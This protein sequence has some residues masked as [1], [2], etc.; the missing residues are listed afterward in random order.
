MHEP[1]FRWF[2][3]IDLK[4]LGPVFRSVLAANEWRW[5]LYSRKE[6]I[7]LFKRVGKGWDEVV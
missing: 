5:A 1:T 2:R 6:P 7:K 3:E 4:P